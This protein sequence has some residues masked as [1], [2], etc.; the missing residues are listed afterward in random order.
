MRTLPPLWVYR[1]MY[2]LMIWFLTP[3]EVRFY[4][5]LI[6][7]CMQNMQEIPDKITI[8]ATIE[9]YAYEQHS[10]IASLLRIVTETNSSFY[11]ATNGVIF[12]TQESFGGRQVDRSQT[13]DGEY[14]R[15]YM[16]MYTFPIPNKTGCVK[17]LT[18]KPWQWD[19]ESPTCPLV[20]VEG[21]ADEEDIAE[22]AEALADAYMFTL[23]EH[24][25]ERENIY[26]S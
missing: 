1:A 8:A 6:L 16:S 19:S 14:M 5:H 15:Q 12:P 21:D 24:N 26:R 13:P 18:Q 20:L 22:C 25:R 10:D 2:I 9:I 23:Y 7:L 3:D 11:A 17:I 4:H